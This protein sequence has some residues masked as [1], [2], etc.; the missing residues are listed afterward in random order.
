M[1]DEKKLIERFEHTPALSKIV[2]NLSFAYATFQLC[3]SL[4]LFQ[5]QQVYFVL[6]L[7][8]LLQ[9]YAIFETPQ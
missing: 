2:H 5:I 9:N 4:I 7:L 8:H 6:I 3:H 1:I